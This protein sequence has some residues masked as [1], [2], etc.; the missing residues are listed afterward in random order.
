MEVKFLG[1]AAAEGWPGLFCQ[2]DVCQRA[3]SMGGKNIRTRSSAIIDRVFKVDFPPDTYHHFITQGVD[4][5]EIRHLFITHA[6]QDHFYPMDLAMRAGP[7]A[8][9]S[10][11]RG[12]DVYGD[13]WVEEGADWGQLAKG[14]VR[15]H[16]IEDGG[17]YAIDDALLYPL[18]A[19]HYPE[20][21]ALNYVFTHRG[22]T[23]LYGHDTGWFLN[24][25][26]EQ[27]QRFRLDLVILD[28]TSGKV[29]CRE[30]HMGIE[31]VTEVKKRLI[32]D[33]IAHSD[34]VFVA[35]HFSHNGGLLHE[36]L[37][38]VLV[39]RGFVVAYDGMV[40]AV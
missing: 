16:R 37:E 2:C 30:G 19:N 18:K 7:F 17:M 36:E 12:L 24:Q 22:T 29:D 40:I 4:M 15:F 31:A 23:L 26:W 27:L 11:D 20:K 39:P 34:T 21:G 38:E 32:D 1:T 28:C 13:R 9:I 8:H 3:R 35:T 14:N 6:H 5:A 33:N 25:T 10:D